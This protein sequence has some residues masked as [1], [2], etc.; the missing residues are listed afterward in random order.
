MSVDREVS[1]GI[2]TN[3]DKF[4]DLLNDFIIEF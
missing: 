4:S 3:R 1:L 2:L